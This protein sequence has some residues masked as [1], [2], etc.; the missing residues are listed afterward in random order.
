MVCRS[1]AKGGAR[2]FAHQHTNCLH[3]QQAAPCMLVYTCPLN[4]C[5]CTH[6]C[7]A[8]TQ[9]PKDLHAPSAHHGGGAAAPPPQT[10]CTTQPHPFPSQLA[11]PNT[12]TPD[13][14]P[15]LLGDS[16]DGQASPAPAAAVLPGANPGVA[17]APGTATTQQHTDCP[18]ACSPATLRRPLP[19]Q[20]LLYCPLAYTHTLT[21]PTQ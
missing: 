14:I 17:I 3:T 1:L 5:A 19:Q 21:H 2:S 11:P 13:L 18:A 16:T 7:T 15:P 4:T 12:H 20:E 8:S 10:Q 6:R 9:L